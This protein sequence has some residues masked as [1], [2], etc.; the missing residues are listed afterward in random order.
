MGRKDSPDMKN[1]KKD[2]NN[3][4]IKEVKSTYF[5]RKL[6]REDA[7]EKLSD[8]FNYNNSNKIKYSN[9][10]NESNDSLL[11]KTCK[12]IGDIERIEFIAGFKNTSEAWSPLKKILRASNIRSR[13]VLLEDQWWLYDHG[14]LLGF[15]KEDKTPVALIRKNK[16]Y[17]IKNIKTGENIVAN[18]L[19]TI[20]IETIAHSFFSPLPSGKINSFLF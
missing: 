13:K 9:T 15:L 1:L 16:K 10:L 19:N 18:N 14:P 7:Y 4:Y 17:I 11:L 8:V 2:I 3:S 5:F 20:G 6:S 12:L